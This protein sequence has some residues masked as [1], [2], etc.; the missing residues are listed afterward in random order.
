MIATRKTI[1]WCFKK[2]L[3]FQLNHF[4]KLTSPDFFLNITHNNYF[5]WKKIN[6]TFCQ[7]K[8]ISMNVAKE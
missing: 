7:A 1:N 4:A 5:R 6:M 2:W 3:I 8:V